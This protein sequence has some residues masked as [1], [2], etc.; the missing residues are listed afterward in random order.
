MDTKNILEKVKTY[1]S[2]T[3]LTYA[4]GVVESL[5]AALKT[6]PFVVISG[7]SGSGKTSLVRAFFAR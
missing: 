3:G 1:I 7:K 6:R 5:F 4:N 2:N